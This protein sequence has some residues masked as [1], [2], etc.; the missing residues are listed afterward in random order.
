VSCETNFDRILEFLRYNQERLGN[1]DHYY[2]GLKT[3]LPDW[4]MKNKSIFHVFEDSA[5]GIRSVKSLNSFLVQNGIDSEVIAYGVARDFQKVESLK[6]EN[7]RIF[8]NINQAL[9][10]YF[11]TR[12]I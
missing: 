11:E 10:Y 9:S 5:I 7:A 4:I 2:I 6:R 8:A 3:I 12:T 1:P